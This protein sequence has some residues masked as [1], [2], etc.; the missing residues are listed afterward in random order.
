MVSAMR[1]LLLALLFLLACSIFQRRGRL[2]P[3]SD[4]K[5][6]DGVPK[7]E[8]TKY[9]FENSKIFPGTMRDYWVYVPKQYTRPSRPAC[10]STR[11]ACSSTPRRCST[12]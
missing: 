10:T 11:T 7:G 1:L 5:P 12:S 4:S 6:Q 8:V 3:R 9:T 2:C